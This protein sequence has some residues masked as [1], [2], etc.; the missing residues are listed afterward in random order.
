[1]KVIII[2]RQEYGLGSAYQFFAVADTPETARKIIEQAIEEDDWRDE[3][4]FRY[5]AWEVRSGIV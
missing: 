5:A 1:M 4:D 2:E 3:D